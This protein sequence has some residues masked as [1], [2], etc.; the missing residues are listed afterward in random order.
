MTLRRRRGLS[1]SPHMRGVSVYRSY[2][3]PRLNLYFTGFGAVFVSLG[4]M[5]CPIIAI[6]CPREE[7]PRKELFWW[8]MVAYVPFVA[9]LAT[10]FFSCLRSRLDVASGGVTLVTLRSIHVIRIRELVS[11]EWLSGISRGDLILSSMNDQA[12]IRLGR[13]RFKNLD[14]LKQLIWFL[15]RRIP[16]DIQTGWRG[17]NSRATLHAEPLLFE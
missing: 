14:E 9:F 6:F 2:R 10:E 13:Y 12:H 16:K 4:M 7:L 3:C 8:I 5:G 11:A 17:S 15:R 1:P